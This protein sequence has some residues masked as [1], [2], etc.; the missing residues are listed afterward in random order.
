MPVSPPSCPL[1]VTEDT[2]SALR[3]NLLSGDDAAR[4]R[5]HLA[6]CSACHA[7]MENF[8]AIQRA[9]RAQETPDLHARV[10]RG[11]AAHTARPSQSHLRAWSWAG[12][13]GGVALVM[14]LALAVAQIPSLTRPHTTRSTATTSPTSTAYPPT[15]TP[16]L[17]APLT[18]A[19]AWGTAGA[20]TFSYD[21][22]RFI[23]TDVLPDAS[24]VV[25]YTLSDDT[26]NI[27]ASV[28]LRTLAGA[29]EP[30][31]TLPKVD[32]LPNVVTDGRYVAWSTPTNYTGGPGPVPRQYIGAYNLQTR[33]VISIIAGALPQYVPSFIVLD[34]GMLFLESEKAA[35]VI[36]AVDLASGAWRTL[37]TAP[38]FTVRFSVSWPYLLYA[39]PG[40]T[41]HLKN[42]VTGAVTDLPSVTTN[43]ALSGTTVY[44]VQLASATDV[45]V[46]ALDHADRPGAQP[47][48]LPD[49][50]AEAA[51]DV[52]FAANARLLSVTLIEPGGLPPIYHIWDL[53]QQR[54]IDL[55]IALSTTS[56]VFSPTLHGSA[57]AYAIHTG[58]HAQLVLWNT[59]MLPT[60]PVAP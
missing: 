32:D 23:V 29:I 37:V 4:L 50:P 57:L 28:E 21:D 36:V 33:Q 13:L 27:P 17:P 10:W 2:L 53:A 20:Q 56:I 8:A 30:L 54:L 19:Q 31:Y 5:A 38:D 1:G 51:S 39:A 44:Y 18:P 16:M 25:G 14:V 34:H 55:P 24:G 48:A 6:E 41:M 42:V 12:G 58:A 59:A 11:V 26:H 46:F 60:Q 22:T 49:E 35:G 9:L 7:H 52:Y 45:Q 47:R 3:D 40:A 43:A 15:P